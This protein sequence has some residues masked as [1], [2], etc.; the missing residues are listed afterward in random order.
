V[1]FGGTVTAVSPD[2]LVVSDITVYLTDKTQIDGELVV[3]AAVK[4]E[5]LTR[6]DGTTIAHKVQVIPATSA[7]GRGNQGGNPGEEHGNRTATPG[8]P[9]KGSGDDSD[10][11]TPTPGGDSGSSGGSTP[12]PA[13]FDVEGKITKLSNNSLVVGGTLIRLDNS[14]EI[15]GTLGEGVMV[16]ARGYVRANGSYLASRVQVLSSGDGAGDNTATATAVSGEGGSGSGSATLTVTATSSPDDGGGGDE[17]EGGGS[18]TATP[19]P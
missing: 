12:Q 11:A 8:H 7:P 5:G 19:T 14:T 2:H 15:R 9:G 3:G 6:P 13:S 18:S 16:R 1:E 10:T 17:D 4:I